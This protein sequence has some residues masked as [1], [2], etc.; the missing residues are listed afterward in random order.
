M[1][2]FAAPRLLLGTLLTATLSACGGS[3]PPAVEPAAAAPEVVEE[4]EQEQEF[5]PF[6]EEQHADTLANTT[7]AA[8]VAEVR[9]G[10][11][12]TVA[13]FFEIADG[14]RLGWLYPGD[15][16]QKLS[17]Q[18]SAPEGFEV[19]PVQYPGPE[20]FE[21]NGGLISYGYKTHAAAFAEITAPSKLDLQ[22]AYRFD[23]KATWMV[24]K[25]ECHSEGTEAFF[26]LSANR[27]AQTLGFDSP[28]QELHQQVARPLSSLEKVQYSWRTSSTLAISAKGVKWD[29]FYP[30][31]DALKPQKVSAHGEQLIVRFARS[32]RTSDS[33]GVARGEL[34][35]QPAFFELKSPDE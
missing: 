31:S 4:E 8:T 16:G 35:G 21:L 7:L 23:A 29:D 24:C 14:Y 15:V 2:E 12:F 20:R 22:E 11:S 30:A 28:L 34:D 17:V 25:K 10:T 6:D 1:T 26:E 3:A 19:G 27:A 9:P 32:A 5:I 18:F 13:L 33:V